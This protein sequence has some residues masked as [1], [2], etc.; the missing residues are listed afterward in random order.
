MRY[1]KVIRK[2]V[3]ALLTSGLAYF[4][5]SLSDQPQ[6]WALT[7]SVF[8]GGATLFVQFMN[9][10]DHHLDYVVEKLEN[11]LEDV[12]ERHELH[13]NEVRSLIDE[14]FARTSEATELFRAV[15][16]S[17]LR[18]D[19]ITQLVRHSTQIEPGSPPLIYGF[20]QSQISRLSQFLK[21]LSEG[22]AVSFDGEDRDWLLGLT[23]QSQHT[24]EAT[25]LSTVDAGG[26]SFHGGLWTSDFG[27]RYLEHQREAIHRGVVI[28][29]IFILDNP[30]QTKESDFLHIYR[31]QQ[32]IGILTKVL[33][34][35]KIPLA[36]KSV[37]F[38]FVVFDGAIS[39]EVTP[40]SRVEDNMKPTI[41]KTHLEL[42]SERVRERM[43]RFENLWDS[44]QEFE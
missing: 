21:E 13:S 36:L 34:R 42:P 43:Q 1:G 14:G 37:L 22:G 7:M 8:I 11:V 18:T 12:V 44:A 3:I 31:Y 4:I 16:A 38:D 20:A 26:R 40:S 27:R 19:M 2:I 25:S 15:E 41:V 9:D 10:F 33:E 24:I 32:D 39:Y 6:I 17:S 35:S 23:M 5:T 29:R 28:R 30:G